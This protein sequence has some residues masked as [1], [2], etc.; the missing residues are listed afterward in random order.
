MKGNLHVYYDEEG[1]YLEI[2]TGKSQKSYCRDIA[3]GVFERIDEETGNIIGI[4]ILSF[5]KRTSK[6]KDI[7]IKIPIQLLLGSHEGENVIA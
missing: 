5:K 4:G 6:K 2:N 7:D 3:D 1:D